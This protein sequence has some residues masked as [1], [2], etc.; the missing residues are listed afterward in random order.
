MDNFER[1][2]IVVPMDSEAT[3]TKYV[4]ASTQRASRAARPPEPSVEAQKL[5]WLKISQC[6]DALEGQLDSMELD[7]TGDCGAAKQQQPVGLQR[8][9]R[10]APTAYASA[11]NAAGGGYSTG[12]AAAATFS[13]S[14]S[15]RSTAG[16][17]SSS[18]GTEIVPVK[19]TV[20]IDASVPARPT[21]TLSHV[22]SLHSRSI[23]AAAREPTYLSYQC[24]LPL[25]G[26]QLA[27]AGLRSNSVRNSIVDKPVGAAG[28]QQTPRLNL[29]EMYSA[30]SGQAAVIAVSLGIAK[31]ESLKHDA[32]R[33]PGATSAVSPAKLVSVGAQRP[34][35]HFVMTSSARLLPQAL[36]TRLCAHSFLDTMK[37]FAQDELEFGGIQRW[38]PPAQH[39]KSVQSICRSVV[40]NADG[41]N[42]WASWVL[43][44]YMISDPRLRP[45]ISN[46]SIS[47]LEVAAAVVFTA[48][49]RSE[50][51]HR[52]RL[53]EAAEAKRQQSA[54]LALQYLV[55]EG[56]HEDHCT[57]S[58]TTSPASSV[59]TPAATSALSKGSSALSAKRKRAG[60]SSVV[61]GSTCGTA[62]QLQSTGITFCE[63]WD[64]AFSSK[65]CTVLK[66]LITQSRA[67]ASAAAV[68]SLTDQLAADGSRPEN[69]LLIALS[70]ENAVK[71]AAAIANLVVTGPD[72]VP[73]IVTWRKRTSKNTI[74]LHVGMIRSGADAENTTMHCCLPATWPS[75]GPALQSP[76]LCLERC[77]QKHDARHQ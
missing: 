29:G 60:S 74:D 41:V 31:H 12:G 58:M 50:V 40:D 62:A 51:T 22:F 17:E 1:R 11:L 6:A 65:Y 63:Y 4:F 3:D 10:L 34:K 27:A 24:V 26:A 13:S 43:L 76:K 15:N 46:S 67:E 73:Q 55:K 9:T 16:S 64:A 42:V 19:T 7:A 77:H 57:E 14:S 20:E 37:I 2:L 70:T 8:V 71:S 32:V 47:D 28:S 21:A 35:S 61:G 36:P 39:S 44:V 45:L 59:A 75:H 5:A 66:T 38:L 30:W 18:K 69:S 56:N 23:E 72:A 52:A 49:G 54:T 48:Y 68:D 33:D 53:E 25:V